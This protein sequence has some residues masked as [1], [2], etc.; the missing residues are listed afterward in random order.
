MATSLNAIPAHLKLQN[1]S[2]VTFKKSPVNSDALSLSNSTFTESGLT[3]CSPIDDDN[4]SIRSDL[5]A[6]SDQFVV[7]GFETMTREEEEDIFSTNR[8]E[9]AD[10]VTE[11]SVV[12]SP[13]D[14]SDAVDTS[15]SNSMTENPLTVTLV[16]I[17][18]QNLSLAQQ[19]KGFHSKILMRTSDVL[20]S[21]F[22]KIPFNEYQTLVNQRVV[23]NTNNTL[24][25]A[26]SMSSEVKLRLESFAKLN[27]KDELI[28]V[29]VNN[30][31]LTLHMDSVMLLNDF[32]T[33]PDMAY[34]PPT[35]ILLN[36]VCITLMDDKVSAPPLAL[37]VPHLSVQ[38][39]RYN[40]MTVTPLNTNV[41]AH[42]EQLLIPH[43]KL[44]L[45][46]GQ[47][48][49]SSIDLATNE[50][51]EPNDD[52]DVLDQVLKKN[53]ILTEQMQR[54]VIE[55]IELKKQINDRIHQS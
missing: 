7:V 14:D 34:V 43:L 28:S 41:S 18:I 20:L 51:R 47:R 31:E 11:H 5:S 32:I 45:R 49:D 4:R 19:S 46:N 1:A 53:E 48:S 17:K 40:Q 25:S 13:S 27:L 37:K 21:E 35:N 30:L 33:D 26:N 6:E 52:N 38:R 15:P 55:N 12:E 16:Q 8:I 2:L 36:N 54:L 29:L 50:K 44:R 42:T 10:E 9:A 23:N 39:D 22:I 24:N 3:D